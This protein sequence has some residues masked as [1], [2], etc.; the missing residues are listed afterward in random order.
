M[1]LKFCSFASGSS[2]NCY[3]VE[4]EGTK[5]LVDVGIAGKKVIGCLEEKNLTPERLDGILITHEHIDHIKSI[6]MMSRKAQNAKIYASRGTASQIGGKVTEEKIRQIF[7]DKP[8]EIGDITVYPFRLSHDA[9]EPTGYSFRCGRK[10]MSIVTDTGRISQEIFEEVADSDLLVL[11]ANHET[12]ILKTGPYP[13]S[14]KQRI[15]GDEGH[16]SNEAAGKCLCR[17][18]RER[19]AGQ[20]IPKVVLAH[21]SGE[22]N[23]PAQAYLTVSNILFEEDFYIGKDLELDVAGRDSISSLF[24]V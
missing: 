6:R 20:D 24:E 17:M 11:E 12:N 1:S 23:T 10:K 7:P 16:L 2:G 18:L 15:L 3:L 22:S 19:I 13:Y 9:A 5:L 21:L 4:S 8:F 14:L